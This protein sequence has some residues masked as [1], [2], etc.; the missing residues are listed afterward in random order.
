MLAIDLFEEAA[1]KKS[2][3]CQK[4]NRAVILIQD[5]VCPEAGNTTKQM[6]MET[7]MEIL[8]LLYS[9]D[10]FFSVDRFKQQSLSIRRF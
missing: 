10:M 9:S 5:N 2:S 6:I 7:E 3:I 1:E 8:P 4:R